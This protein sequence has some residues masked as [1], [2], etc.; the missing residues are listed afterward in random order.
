VPQVKFAVRKNG[1]DLLATVENRTTSALAPAYVVIGERLYSCGEL[2][3]GQTATRALKPDIS[4]VD[5]LRGK[6]QQFQ[7]AC[8]SRNYAFANQAEARLDDLPRANVAMSFLSAIDATQPHLRFLSPPG[9][10]LA[11]V[12][13]HGG[14][15]LLAWSDN[16]SP[17]A[18]IQQFTPK[19]FHRQTF[20]RVI[21]PEGLR[22][23]PGP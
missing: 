9:T 8:S 18:P 10:D 3:A 4:I 7:T 11:S 22:E 16:F 13:Y 2:A 17:M 20:W 21:L 14:A 19:R 15:V 1:P 23:T 6:A 5:L 12:P